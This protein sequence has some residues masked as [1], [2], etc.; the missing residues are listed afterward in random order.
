MWSDQRAEELPDA[1]A[2]QG[3][4][5]FLVREL[6]DHV[7]TSVTEGR[8]VIEVVRHPSSAANQFPLKGAEFG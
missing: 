2:E 3:R 8:S 4:G 6:A 1:E 5:L 7:T